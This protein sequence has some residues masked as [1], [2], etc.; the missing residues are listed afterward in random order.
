MIKVDADLIGVQNVSCLLLKTK[1][2][3][4]R[5]E[6]AICVKGI[7][8]V[9][10]WPKKSSKKLGIGQLVKDIE[11]RKNVN[12]NR[13][14]CVVSLSGGKDSLG[15]LHIAKNVLHL[16]PVAVFIDNGF[17]PEQLFKNAFN[18]ADA[19]GVELQIVKDDDFAKVFRKI[20]LTKK[21]FYYCRICHAMIDR[22]V[23]ET[24]RK[25]DLRLIL[26]GFTK[27]QNYLRM[28]ELYGIFKDTDRVTIEEMA[29]EY[30]YIKE[31]FP[32]LAVYFHRKYK[33]IASISPFWYIKWSEDELIDFLAEHYGFS[34]PTKSWPDR[35]S[36][37]LFNYV[38]QYMAEKKFGY[39]QH[40][41]E[42]STLIR[43][44][45]ITRERAIEILNTPITVEQLDEVLSMVDLTL[46]D[47]L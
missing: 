3:S 17:I 19:M 36:N 7:I 39:S 8:I 25:N 33:E 18:A 44:G 22:H 32:N 29:G 23:R 27:G 10:I 40:E 47:I 5:M 9:N 13:N 34:I 31:M 15:I 42:L 26:G 43:N 35:S 16:N 14:D 12:R 2:V 4:M 46:E 38:A 28:R 45:E 11:K 21:P 41:V 6:Y 20:L 1:F 30:D 37:C 24:A